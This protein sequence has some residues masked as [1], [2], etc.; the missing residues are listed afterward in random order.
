[1]FDIPGYTIN[2]K[3]AEGACAE[4]Y[5]GVDQTTGMLVAIK[6]LHPRHAVNKSEYKRLAEEGALG[7]RLRQQGQQDNIVHTYRVGTDGELPYV[8]LEYVD[9]RTLREILVERKKLSEMEVLKLAKGLARG[10][11]FLH[12]AGVCHKDLKPDNIMVTLDGVV[13]MLDFG[14]AENYKAFRLFRPSLEGSLPYMA[15]EMFTT[16][17]S[18]PST[19]IYALGCTLYECAAGFQPFG[20]MS[21]NEIVAK[22]TNLKL[23]PLAI[24]QGSPG[25]SVF[26]ERMIMM[27]LEKEPARRFKSADEVLLDLARNP[28]LREANDSRVLASRHAT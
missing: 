20:G 19:D 4:I 3:L 11:R 21:D 1:M 18:T 16:K 13:K 2:K 14:F 6:R 23:T 15:P 8:V 28:S 5:A 17:R 26:T 12:N 25:I 27:A 9:G 10:L 24:R 7:L 22:Q